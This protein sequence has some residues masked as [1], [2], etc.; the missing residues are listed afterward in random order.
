LSSIDIVLRPHETGRESSQ[1]TLGT[2]LTISGDF[3]SAALVENG[4]YSFT[5]VREYAFFANILALSLPRDCFWQFACLV[6][7]DFID[8]TDCELLERHCKVVFAKKPSKDRINDV[9]RYLATPDN[10]QKLNQWLS[11]HGNGACVFLSVCL[12]VFFFFCLFICSSFLSFPTKPQ[13]SEMA[14]ILIWKKLLK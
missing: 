4:T 2:Q 3:Y 6:G 5:I 14:E 7:N 12:S 11:E 13:R 10:G 9:I 8:S 1:N